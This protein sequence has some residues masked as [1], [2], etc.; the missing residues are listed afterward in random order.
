MRVQGPMLPTAYCVVSDRFSQSKM[1]SLSRT[2]GWGRPRR[3]NARQG[4]YITTRGEGAKYSALTQASV[5]S[6]NALPEML[7]NPNFCFMS[8]DIPD[9][10]HASLSRTYSLNVARHQR[11]IFWIWVSEYPARVKGLAPPFHRECVFTRSMGIPLNVGYLR[12]PTASLRAELTCS[13]VTS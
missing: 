8:Q 13:E 7:M 4:S 10:K 6:R 1:A 12:A 9:E 2:G 3:P 11:P 5:M